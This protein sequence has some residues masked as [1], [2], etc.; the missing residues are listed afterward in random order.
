MTGHLSNNS[1][2]LPTTNDSTQPTP[3]IPQEGPGKAV[4]QL[5]R[6]SEARFRAAIEAIQGVLWT[7][8]AIG[9]ME[10]EQ[11]G[12]G[13]LTG[14]TYKEYQGYGWASAVHPDDAQPTIDSWNEA[15]R[16][17]KPFIFEHRVRLKS[18]IYALFSV[19]AVPVLNDNGTIREWVG[20]H[21][22]ITA[23][24]MADQ[25]LRNSEAELAF[26]IDAAELGIWDLNPQTNR[27]KGNSRLKEW[28]G[29]NADEEIE[30][31]F[32]LSVI[33]DQ[34]QQRVTEAIERAL[35][36]ESG[37][38]YDVEYTIIHP[39]TGHERVVRAKGKVQFDAKKV[40]SRFN[41]ILQDITEQVFARRQIEESQQQLLVFFE[42]SPVAVA[43]I[44]EDDL[45]F[46]MANTFY[47]QL[48]GRDPNELIN[49]PLLEA[50][51]ELQGQGFDQLLQRVIHTGVPFVANEVKIDVLRQNQLETIYVN[52]AYHPQREA[53][54]GRISGVFVIATDV[55]LQVRS[56]Q[57]V[58]IS[59]AKL[60]S[61]ISAAP[62]AIAL[63][64][65]RD[66][67]IELP[68]QA[69]IDVAGKGPDIVGK[70]LREVMPELVT[71][72]QP[73]LQILDDVYTSG[74]MFQSF[75]SM[76]QIVQ[77]GVMTNKFYNFTY[78]PLLNEASEVYAILDIA[79]EVTGQIQVQEELAR[80]TTYLQTALSIANLG[81]FA[82][83]LTTD[84]GT[85]SENVQQW[86]GLPSVQESM[87]T[88]L[89]RIH[90]DDLP[91]VQQV[92]GNALI[93]EEQ[94]KHDFIYRVINPTVGS[95]EYIRS[96]GKAQFVDG[97]PER[98]IGI[99]EN[100]T[101]EVVA[102]QKMDQ[103]EMALRGAIELAQ[104][105]TWSIDIEQ[106]TI[107]YSQRFMDWLGFSEETKVIDESYN[108]LPEE[109]RQSVSNAL[110]ATW[111]S[112][113]TGVYENEHPIINRITGQV[114]II[115]AQGQVHYNSSGKPLTLN[116]TAQDVTEQRRLQH[117]LE[118]QVQERT[119]QLQASIGDLERS[120]QNLQQFA[121]VASHDLQEP[122]RKIQS[123]GDLLK[124]QYGDQLGEG[125][126][127]LNRMQSSAFR[128]SVLIKD[129]L[130]YSR[131][132]T[133]QETVS[134]VQLNDELKSVLS[135]LELAIAD[136]HAVIDFAPLPTVL[137]DRSQL[138][139]LFQNL[140]SNSLKFRKKER[141]DKTVLPHIT[142]TVDLVT[143][144]D[145]PAT[146]RPARPAPAFYRIDIRDNGIG[147]D[148]R[149]TDR[150]FQVFQRLHG[151]NEYA[152]TG[153]GLA[154]CEKV[155]ANHGG[156]I[157]ATS[158]LG[159]GA[160]FSIYLPQ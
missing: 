60:Q 74:K 26:A 105:V 75:G 96:M 87:S 33:A 12:W 6:E 43:I 134:P 57:R 8:N 136:A 7:N 97:K 81:T 125:V 11:P 80:Q 77:N 25:A 50:L 23:S 83:D 133:R 13:A 78:T 110:E 94:S 24:R 115:H 62:V 15:V 159:K 4:E 146:V 130:T 90:P 70:P 42:Q 144:T 37:G 49:K 17:Q 92:I 102:R 85:F 113:G 111:Q 64:I 47:G 142:I 52:L 18:G 72:D 54:S 127:Y 98:I 31:P 131:I 148:Q 143:A 99:L 160:T 34:D 114:R 22:N 16:E 79:V 150:I 41:G 121:Y 39:E 55:T 120:N 30:L 138:R 126:D 73:F 118:Q 46:R 153:I 35:D 117:E 44:D 36:Y 63:F 14:Q 2:Q 112:G 103:A 100:V 65:G 21:T 29:L 95:I 88:I 107:S 151:K 140:I 82:V 128:M 9:E 139:Q 157:T 84:T 154:I 91:I 38:K 149:Y 116:G 135:D 106:G 40:A 119:A 61:V 3:S 53:G 28:F 76:V 32:A 59:E 1:N 152:G 137:G 19:R 156:A 58:E 129:L 51:P 123:F 132:S 48:V 158:I 141:S 69:F 5:L 45:T 93:S 86:F 109:Y 67:T 56:R 71:E 89:S 101:H 108:P 68:N 155:A 66:L 20:V 147:F 124:T 104:L 122:L 27:F 10:G 145:L